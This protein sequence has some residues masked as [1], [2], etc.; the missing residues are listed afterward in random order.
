MSNLLREI[1]IPDYPSKIMV[2]ESRAKAYYIKGKTK[3]PV[4]KKYSPKLHPKTYGYDKKGYLINLS[5]K[6]RV[7]SN[8]RSAGTPRYWVV[9]FQDIWSGMH[10]ST[11][12]NRI[13]LLKDI[14]KPFIKP[15]KKITTYPIKIEIFLY[16][17]EMNVDV[18][19]KGVIYTK[20]ITDLL[21][22]EEKIEDD[23][24]EY[25][26]DTGR[27]KFIKVNDIKERKMIVKIWESN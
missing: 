12:S 1:C 21:V 4:P 6:E 19:N 17:I 3:K 13:N 23:S 24:H 15:V 20:V 2:S 22:G 9:N 5:T 8:P 25:V 11:K 18:D 14:I 27:C 10:H 26:N 7:L 16:D